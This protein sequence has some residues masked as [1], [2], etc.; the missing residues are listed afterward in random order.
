M[1]PAEAHTLGKSSAVVVDTEMAE[2]FIKV[3]EPMASCVGP[4]FERNTC[5]I[6]LLRTY[7]SLKEREEAS[8]G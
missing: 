7:K 8:V 4:L 2:G 5:K 6:L 3:T 1:R